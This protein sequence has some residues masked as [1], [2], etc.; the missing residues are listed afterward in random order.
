MR[1]TDRVGLLQPDLLPSI[2]VPGLQPRYGQEPPAVRAGEAEARIPLHAEVDTAGDRRHLR[3]GEGRGHFGQSGQA[4]RC[5][6][7]VATGECRILIY[8]HFYYL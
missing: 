6:G 4:L 3:R 2:R 1:P 7:R 8:L 5:P